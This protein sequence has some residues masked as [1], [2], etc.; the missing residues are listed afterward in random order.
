MRL[1]SAACVAILCVSPVATGP[2]GRRPNK[3]TCQMGIAVTDAEYDALLAA[4]RVNRLLWND[5]TYVLSESERAIR[6][7]ADAAFRAAVKR[8]DAWHDRWVA[9]PIA[10]R[11]A[12]ELAAELAERGMRRWP[13]GK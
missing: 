12:V 6:A 10:N 11:D 4:E 1:D 7:A 2:A 9:A 5:G 8:H 13:W 3:G